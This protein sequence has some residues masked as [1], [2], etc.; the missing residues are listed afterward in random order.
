LRD[1]AARAGINETEMARVV[2]EQATATTASDDEAAASEGG[3]RDE[4]DQPG[5]DDQAS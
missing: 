5:E 1:A 3:A 2:V 4:A